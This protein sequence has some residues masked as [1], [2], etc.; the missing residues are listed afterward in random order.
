MVGTD[1]TLSLRGGADIRPTGRDS[2]DD[3][4]GELNF[5]EQNPSYYNSD[6]MDIDGS[7][8]E[9]SSQELSLR[10]FTDF[11]DGLKTVKPL[12]TE[13]EVEYGSMEIV[14]NPWEY[15]DGNDLLPSI[16]ALLKSSL[17]E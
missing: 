12:I 9:D 2:I 16:K 5:E 17:S 3:D 1:E 14:Q 7:D 6:G 4:I 11:P 8:S 13:E 10:I 15:I